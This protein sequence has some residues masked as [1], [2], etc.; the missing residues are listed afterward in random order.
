MG[1]LVVTNK[2]NEIFVPVSPLSSCPFGC[3][4]VLDIGKGRLTFVHLGFIA[5]RQWIFDEGA[6]FSFSLWFSAVRN[7]P[8]YSTDVHHSTRKR[9]PAALSPCFVIKTLEYVTI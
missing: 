4:L 2:G 7:A 9:C 5:R 3:R 6:K 8:S 1:S